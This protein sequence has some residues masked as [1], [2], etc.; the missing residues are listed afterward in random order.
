MNGHHLRLRATALSLVVL[1]LIGLTDLHGQQP[2]DSGQTDPEVTVE[3]RGRQRSRFR[4]AMPATEG[5]TGLTG[6]MAQAAG[7]VESTLR[8]DLEQSGIFDVQ[9]PVQLSVLT[10]SG[11]PTRDFELYRSLRNE[12][13]L[14]TV[15]RDE[16][17]KLVLEGRVFDLKS[18]EQVIGKRYRG[19]AAA[20]RRIAH[21]FADELVLFFSGRP[22]ISLTSIA[23]YSDR[24]GYKEIY[25]MD[26]DGENQRPIT[27]HK[28]ISMSP[29]WSPT[30]E[31][32]AYVSYFSG[33]PGIYLA[34]LASGR[35]S[36]VVT[37][38]TLNISPTFS[39]DG[40][41]LAFARSVGA[42]NTELFVCNRD[43]SGPRQLTHSSGIDTNPSW[44]PTGRRV[45]F[46]SS[47]TGT[48]QIYVVDVEGAN[49]RRVSFEGD[50]NDGA[51]WSPDGTRLVYASRRRGSFDIVV[52]D[53]VTLET[54]V[55]TDWEGSHE[56]P[57]FSP[58]GRKIVFS[59]KRLRGGRGDTQIWVIDAD[60]GN[61]RQLTT[62]GNNLGPA[63]SGLSP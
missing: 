11:D 20:S 18:G 52:T 47:R 32:L 8:S 41:E 7:V 14:E 22:G 34:D 39:P 23:F 19:V 46:T 26:F 1:G 59:S 42:G 55:I 49:L 37:T 16:L 60:G 58:D 38:G 45:A 28:S 13:L 51:S 61:R 31:E 27:G 12:L 6:E 36:P 40:R 62:L 57:S 30:G 5:A 2:P 9:G 33:S 15:V 54:R 25:L 24:D 17:G 3:L 35:K 63:W 4:L 56:T 53:V 21:T 44:S 29:A 50:Y 48:P 43:G 10:L